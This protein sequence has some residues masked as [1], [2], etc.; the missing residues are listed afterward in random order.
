MRALKASLLLYALLCIQV[1]DWLTT[2][3][4]M[5]FGGIEGNPLMRHMFAVSPLLALLPKIVVVP[6]F[7]WFVY[8]KTKSLLPILVA[9]VI[10]AIPVVWNIAQLWAAGLL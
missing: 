3:Y 9:L 5:S 1:A 10:S 4:A 6:L 7:A 8:W 2:V